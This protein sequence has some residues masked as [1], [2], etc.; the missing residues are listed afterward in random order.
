MDRRLPIT[1]L[2]VVDPSQRNLA[3][4]QE[5]VTSNGI[6]AVELLTRAINRYVDEDDNRPEN[7]SVYEATDRPSHSAEPAWK[8]A[9]LDLLSKHSKSV[10]NANR[11]IQ[12]F[13]CL[14]IAPEDILKWWK[15]ATETYPKLARIV[16]AIPATSAPSE[17]VFSI[18]GLTINAKRSSLAPSSVDKVVFVHENASIVSRQ[19]QSSI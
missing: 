13:R 18:A 3:S 2:S 19:E 5:Y 1:E 6:T 9:K 12:Q 16:L 14:S 15:S 4:V 7:A 8:K 17:R 10:P 11:E